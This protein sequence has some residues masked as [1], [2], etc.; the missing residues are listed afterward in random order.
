M[1]LPL[2]A[3][4]PPIRRSQGVLI[5]VEV[6]LGHLPVGN[7]FPR[8]RDFVSDGNP[9]ELLEWQASIKVLHSIVQHNCT[10]GK[11]I[12]FIILLQIWGQ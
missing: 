9:C 1:L 2:K 12:K 3:E 5:S 8:H 7:G 10:E 4:T 6:E 11:E